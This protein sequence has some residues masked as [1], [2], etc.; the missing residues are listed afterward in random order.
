M[1]S[2]KKKETVTVWY[3]LLAFLCL[4]LSVGCNNDNSDLGE[5]PADWISELP[6]TIDFDVTG[7]V[8]EINLKW[9]KNVN[10]AHVAC[11][12]AEENRRW[13]DVKLENSVLS[14]SVSPS[15]FG[16]SA[17]VTLAL[18]KDHKSVLYV[19]QKS[20]FS[21]YF[22]DE[23]CSEL[24]D[25]HI[26]DTE[27]EKIPHK[28]M[29]EL[30]RELKAGTYSTEFRVA[31]FRPYQHPSVMAA[32]NKTG[33]YGLRDNVTGIYA[34]EGDEMYVYVG[35]IYEDA[36]ISLLIQD[37]NG[38]YNNFKTLEIHEG[39]NRI[40]APIGGLI[41]ILNH[42][43]DNL[44]LI[45]QTDEEKKAIADKS[46]SVHFIFGR[47][48]GYFDK[49]K[50]QTQEKWEEILANAT[51]QDI[52]VLGDYSHITWNVE[53]F[54]GNNVQSNSGIVT[55][56]MKTID[57]CDRLVYLEEEFMGLVKYNKMFNNRMHFCL[58]YKAES[59]NATDYR[60][61][62]SAGAYYA[63]IFCNPERFPQRLWP[64]AT[65]WDTL[66]KLAPD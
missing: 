15:A 62:Y 59:P 31:D 27:I 30:A 61:V 45:P 53:Q 51:Y 14:I 33:K 18:D 23:T 50:H 34:A 2:I 6:A 17:A 13:C 39:L 55:D 35:K 54:K 41:Y 44:P 29:R 25:P 47:V 48:N 4:F 3:S 5:I 19:N 37:L 28:I 42:V 52:D 7:G 43:E 20:D 64:P 24:K 57:N 21:A 66:T 46:V 10:P 22:T 56:I 1:K 8:K 9:N 32:I 58:D 49:N 60:T 11:I 65:R 63:E 40:I 38:G 16:R 26:S 36:Q 12:L